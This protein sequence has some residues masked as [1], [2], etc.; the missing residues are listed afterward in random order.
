VTSADSSVSTKGLLNI[1]LLPG[2]DRL[3]YHL[4]DAAKGKRRP[5]VITLDGGEIQTRRWRDVIIAQTTALDANLSQSLD[6]L[7]QQPTRATSTA[8][9]SVRR[10]RLV[11]AG[12]AW[13]EPCAAAG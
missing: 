8:A 7:R 13:S 5:G 11:T 6:G 12:A 4:A 3:T 10:T 2:R 9:C 1:F